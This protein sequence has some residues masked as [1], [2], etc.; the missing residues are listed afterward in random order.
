MGTKALYRYELQFNLDR[1]S[2]NIRYLIE[3]KLRKRF[4]VLTS[5]RLSFIIIKIVTLPLRIV[6]N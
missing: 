2:F 3:L 5:K 6:I 1:L 4:N